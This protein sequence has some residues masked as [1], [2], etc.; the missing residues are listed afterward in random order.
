MILRKYYVSIKSNC[1][2]LYRVCNHQAYLVVMPS[3]AKREE[4]TPG[5]KRAAHK[6]HTI[7]PIIMRQLRA[8][9][10]GNKEFMGEHVTHPR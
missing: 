1:F 2:S 8:D 7:K 3:N 6:E 5:R 4:G 10:A 9:P